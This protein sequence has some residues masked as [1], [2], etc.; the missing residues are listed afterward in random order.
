MRLLWCFSVALAMAAPVSVSAQGCSRTSPYADDDLEELGSIFY[1]VDSEADRGGVV[2][3]LT[4][5][6]TAYVVRDDA[7]CQAVLARVLPYLRQYH[8]TW[9]QG[10]EG[11]FVA[12]IYR[13]GPYY[14]VEVVP[15]DR[16]S[17]GTGDLAMVKHAR[18]AT[19]LIYSASDLTLLRLLA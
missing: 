9:A 3:L 15:E 10:Q 11:N 19:L 7:T 4:L 12:T 1:D 13:F 2:R 14:A 16:S 17:P 6:D 5:A 18:T 8:P